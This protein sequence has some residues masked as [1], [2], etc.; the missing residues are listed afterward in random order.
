MD[1]GT[2]VVDIIGTFKDLKGSI[3]VVGE[4]GVVGSM[5]ECHIRPVLCRLITSKCEFMGVTD[6]DGKQDERA[7]RVWRCESKAKIG[8]DRVVRCARGYSGS[9]E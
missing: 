5:V 8:V 6:E 7:E 3:G 2:G 1:T 4:S 9:E